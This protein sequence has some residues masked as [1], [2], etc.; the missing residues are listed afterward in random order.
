MGD[1]KSTS[2]VRTFLQEAYEKGV[3]DRN[4]HVADLN[5]KLEVRSTSA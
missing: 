3:A 4:K 5:V 2:N 1:W